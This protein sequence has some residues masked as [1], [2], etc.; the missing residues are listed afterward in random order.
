ME[1]LLVPSKEGDADTIRL[2]ERFTD[3]FT[4]DSMCHY[5]IVFPQSAGEFDQVK[6]VIGN[7]PNVK[8]YVVETP[9]YKS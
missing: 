4:K 2:R 6:V 7:N 3:L 5:R 9:T 1:S 8:V